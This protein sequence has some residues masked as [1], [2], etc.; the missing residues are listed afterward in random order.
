[1]GFDISLEQP[2]G[3]HETNHLRANAFSSAYPEFVAF[4]ISRDAYWS[5]AEELAPDI[6]MTA[7]EYVA[8]GIGLELNLEHDEFWIQLQF[9]ERSVTFT[10]PN[11]PRLGTGASVDAVRPYIEH[12]LRD[13]WA[14][15]HP[16]TGDPIES[17]DWVIAIRE[18]YAHRQGRVQHVADATGGRIS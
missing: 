7:A 1:M 3:R 17:V 12:F 2:T 10:L 14:L 13:G 9:W 16:T 6:G 18:G 15:L 11:F 8:R 5:L 4:E